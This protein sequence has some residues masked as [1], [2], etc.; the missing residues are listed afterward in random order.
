MT[1]IRTSNDSAWGRV[2]LFLGLAVVMGVI[3]WVT[4]LSGGNPD[5][6]N[7]HASKLVAAIDIGVLVFRE[8]LEAILVLAALTANL[9]GGNRSLPAADQLRAPWRRARRHAAH[10]VRCRR[11]SI[12]DLGESVPALDLQAA[13]GLLAIVVLLVV[14]NWFFHKVYWTGWISAHTPAQADAAA[15][16]RA[17]RCHDERC[18]G[19]SASSGSP[20]STAKASRWCCS[21]RATA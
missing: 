11:A 21:F 17:G 12:D 16:R 4:H 1:D 7:P 9:K 19:G 18:G 13:T 20:R 5:P 8:G 14:M 6:T 15:G 2:L 3:L 10:L